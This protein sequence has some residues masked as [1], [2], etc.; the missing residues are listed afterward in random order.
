M[1]MWGR[2]VACEAEVLGGR[3][4]V[5]GGIEGCVPAC[6]LVFVSGPV[7]QFPNVFSLCVHAIGDVNTCLAGVCPNKAYLGLAFARFGRPSD[8]AARAGVCAM[9]VM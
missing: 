3:G 6:V 1:S 7:R 9:A 4:P 8:G 2:Q 5:L